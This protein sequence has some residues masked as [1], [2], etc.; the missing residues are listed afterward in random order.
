M[1]VNTVVEVEMSRDDIEEALVEYLLKVFFTEPESKGW[2]DED[3]HVDISRGLVA[4]CAQYSE[5][6]ILSWN[7]NCANV[8][9]ALNAL[10]GHHCLNEARPAIIGKCELKVGGVTVAEANA[11]MQRIF[12]PTDEPV[13]PELYKN[14]KVEKK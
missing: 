14:D 12:Q 5:E 4:I 6:E 7:A 8:V 1:K 2:V 9:A 11:K 3:M 13:S 10:R